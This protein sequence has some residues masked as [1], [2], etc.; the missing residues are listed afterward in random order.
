MDAIKSV[1]TCEPDYL[2]MGMSGITFLGGV[3]G[4][5]AFVRQVEEVAGVCN[6]RSA[7]TPPPRRSGPTAG[8]RASRSCRPTGR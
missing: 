1:M 8:F 3:K 6:F 7:V 2:V 5:D 4:A